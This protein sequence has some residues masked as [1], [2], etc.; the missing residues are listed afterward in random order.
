MAN[1][2]AISL[3]DSGAESA[4]AGAGDAVD[5]EELRSAA[6]LVLRVTACS[7]TLSTTVQTSPDGSTGWRTVR[8]LDNAT[9]IG[10]WRYAL[11]DLERYLRVIWT[12]GTSATFALAGEA[13]QLYAEP[14]D[15]AGKISDL[16]IERARQDNP[17]LRADALIKASDE[18]QSALAVHY[19][20]PIATLPEIIRDKT[21]DLAAYK[22]LARIGFVGGGTDE[23][24]LKA[25]DEALAW[26]DL[27]R[28]RKV[29]PF[30][31][32]PD[33]EDAVHVSTADSLAETET[34]SP[35]TW[36]DWGDFG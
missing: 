1:P 13:H 20:L 23:I 26:V 10:V 3:H 5:L 16:V 27:L 11:D 4:G 31:T 36:T 15:L 9:S 17:D 12:V 18:M 19:T 8:L 22:L 29:L 14:H 34:L 35:L 28:K 7:G 21:G 6:K 24:V 33:P 32:V 25:Y 30:G 2:L